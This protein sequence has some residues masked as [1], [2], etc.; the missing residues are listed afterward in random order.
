MWKLIQKILHRMDLSLLKKQYMGKNFRWKVAP[1]SPMP[2]KIGDPVRC[3]GVYESE[4]YGGVV[5]N[6]S[7]GVPVP[8]SRIDYYLDPTDIDFSADAMDL[9][10]NNKKQGEIK[11]P[12]EI[13][14]KKTVEQPKVEVKTETKTDIFAGFKKTKRDF[15][16]SLNIELPAS[17]LLTVMYNNAD[18]KKK[19]LSDLG[20]YILSNLKVDDIMNSLKEQFEPETKINKE[21]EISVD[22][23]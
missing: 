4:N 9:G 7:S 17:E 11:T 21:K 22:E 2:I 12:E 20:E 15:D 19:F 10:L 13:L 14:G 5:L 6:M 16:L 8:L 18:D 1:D 3:M 23:Q